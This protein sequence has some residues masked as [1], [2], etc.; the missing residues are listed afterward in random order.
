[1]QGFFGFNPG[2]VVFVGFCT[3]LTSLIGS[4]WLLGLT[5]GLGAVCFIPILADI[6]A[7]ILDKIGI[8]CDK[9]S[10]DATGN[11]IK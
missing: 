2:A 1:M 4:G 3:S 11:M 8:Y 9:R 5:V 7:S 6:L 10:R